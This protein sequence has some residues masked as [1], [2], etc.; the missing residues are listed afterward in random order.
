MLSAGFG[1]ASQVNHHKRRALTLCH[2]PIAQGQAW[3]EK[4]LSTVHRIDCPVS[5]IVLLCRGH[6]LMGVYM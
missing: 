2:E 1:K 5:S 6:L 3:L 4:R